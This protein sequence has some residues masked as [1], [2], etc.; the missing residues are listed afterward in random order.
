MT[1][2]FKH[3][4]RI[5]D[6]EG[7]PTISELYHML[8]STTENL[9]SVQENFSSEV[10]KL[11]DRIAKYNGLWEHQDA[12]DVKYRQ[13]DDALTLLT[14]SVNNL[15]RAQEHC[16]L[17]QEERSKTY[18]TLRIWGGWTFGILSSLT[19]ILVVLKNLMTVQG[20]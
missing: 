20:R 5:E 18:N 12:Q 4:R 19:T 8:I 15:T 14:K 13:L 16:M 2:T 17:R 10:H 11:S 7:T 6:Q 3:K 9:A 1:D